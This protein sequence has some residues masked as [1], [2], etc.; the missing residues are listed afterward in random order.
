MECLYHHIFGPPLLNLVLTFEHLSCEFWGKT[1]QYKTK[2]G[3]IVTIKYANALPFLMK[4]N[5]LVTLS[6]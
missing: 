2:V 6:N 5:Y 1:I 4:E 3:I